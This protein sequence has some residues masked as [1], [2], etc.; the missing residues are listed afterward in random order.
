MELRSGSTPRILLSLFC[1]LLLPTAGASFV[2]QMTQGKVL[3]GLPL[4]Q[5]TGSLCCLPL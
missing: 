3:A 4:S 1:Y 5:N 2:K